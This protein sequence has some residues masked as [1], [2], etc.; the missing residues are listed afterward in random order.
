MTGYFKELSFIFKWR[1]YQ[2]KVLENFAKHITDNHFHIIAPPGSGKTILGLEIIR[3]L[4]KKTIILSPTLTI[5]NQ[6]NERL[7]EFF[8]KNSSFTNYSFDIK[9]PSDITFSTY[10]GLHAFFKTFKTKEVYFD[11]FTTHNI[12]VV[13]VDEAHHLKN[14]WWKCLYE[15]K[16]THNQTIVALTATPPYDSERTEIKK[17]FDLC[18]EIDDEIV[19]PDLIKERNLCPHQDLVYLSIPEQKEIEFISDFRLNVAKFHKELITNKEFISFVKSHRFY[20]NTEQC[21]EDIYKHSPFF[22]SLLIFLNQ[23]KQEIPIEKLVFLGFDA[24][25]KVEFPQLSNKWLEILFQFILITDREKLVSKEKYLLKIEKQLRKL[26]IFSNKQIDFF[27]SKH[28]RKTLQKSPSKLKSIKKI[29]QLEIN[30]LQNDL[31]CVILTD[32]IKSEFLTTED[33]DIQTIKNLGV[34]PIFQHIRTSILHK[35]QLAVLSGSIVIIHNSLIAKIELLSSLEYFTF[36]TLKCDAEFTEISAKTNTSTVQLITELFEKGYIKILIGTKSLLGEGWDAPAINSLILA[37]TVGSFVTSNQMRGRAIRIDNE[38]P[39]KVGLIWHLACIDTTLEKGGSDIETL[40][41]RFNSFLGIDNNNHPTISNGIDRIGLPTSINEKNITTVN[42][43]TIEIAKNRNEIT[44]NWEKAIKKG[45]QISSILNYLP[46][47]KER[48]Y[49]PKKVITKDLVKYGITNIIIGLSLFLPRFLA[50]NLIYILN[51]G[52]LYF[53]YTLLSGLLL[54]FGYDFYKTAQL[55]F[56][57]GFIHK[58]VDK[59]AEIILKTMDELSLLSTPLNSIKITSEMTIN[60]DIQCSITNATRLEST[61]FTKALNELLLPVDNPKY[62]LIKTNW[63]KKEFEV[64]NFYAVPELFS[65]RKKEALLFQKH[66][67]KHLGKSKLLYTRN[68]KGRKLL[69][70]ARFYHASVVDKEI[71]RKNVVWK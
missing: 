22:S 66:W 30:N 53:V 21:L 57:F 8:T 31:R 61:F 24:G 16:E 44:I 15:L 4:D 50:R 56:R 49:K 29:L 18:G 14:E 71:T 45:H 64:E 63:F 51:K 47:S 43:N 11:F 37:S 39:K 2:A 42:T 52:V 33:N 6:W 68:L 62:L 25:E 58:K 60:G 67:S 32:Y 26:N 35:N 36:K 65:N 28:I 69:L 20:S 41:R 59:M 23:A 5:R 40:K 13:L 12:E 9:N 55:Y 17:Y 34:I 7:Q 27:G 70:K 19:V 46:V 54:K 10:Q 1:P 3:R 48:N 38:N